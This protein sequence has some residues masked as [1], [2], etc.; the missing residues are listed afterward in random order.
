MKVPYTQIRVAGLFLL[1]SATLLISSQAWAMKL[2]NQNLTQLISTSESIV[3]GTVK[4][5]TDGI[6]ANG[7]PYTEVT[8]AVGSTAKGR[9]KA[10]SDYTFRQF[11]L[12]EPRKMAGGRTYLAVT[13]EGFPRW[14]EGETVA[15]FMYKP[16]SQTGLQTTAGLTYGKFNLVNGTLVNGNGNV[17]LFEDVEINSA[18]LDPQQT[19]MFETK[20]AVDAATFMSLVG[21]AV[22]EGWIEN[23]EMK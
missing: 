22:S 18:L 6:D 13:P 14:A 11:G 5:V 8:L 19:E 3:M 15:A 1:L 10:D 17:G 21:R 20:G 16:A 9:I 4:S 23:G 2:V 12:L 7:V